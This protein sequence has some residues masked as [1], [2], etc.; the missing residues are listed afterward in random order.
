MVLE[1]LALTGLPVAI[2]TVEGVRYHNEKEAEKE[3][4]VRM[5][6]FHIDVYCSSTSRK[7]NEVHNTMVVL[8]GKKLY[9]ARKDSET[10]MPLS[11]DPASPPP[12]PFTGF[13]L[14]HY[15]EGAARSDSMFTRLNRAEKI[16]GLV[17]TISDHPPT[18]NWVYVDRQTLELKYGNRDDV[19]GH[20]VGP[21]DWTED[22]VGLTFEGWEGFVAVE[23]QKGIWAVYFDRDD[24][25][26]KGV[27]SGKRVLPCSLERRLLDD[28]E[29][30]TR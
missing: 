14:D 30:V 2:A 26:L 13:F 11:A 5:R 28:E 29:V 17:S 23:E 25:R 12:H 18:L 7:R 24:D 10:E 21:W 3:D 15:P 20:I 4:A 6:D 22:E 16:R 27:V 19:E 8:S 1:L 9:L